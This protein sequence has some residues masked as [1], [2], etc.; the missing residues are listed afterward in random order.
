MRTR[1]WRAAPCVADW[2]RIG[3][4]AARKA[5]S[6]GNERDI[7]YCKSV[8]GADSD[9]KMAHSLRQVKGTGIRLYLRRLWM[10]VRVTRKAPGKPERQS[11]CTGHRTPDHSAY[12]RAYHRYASRRLRGD[13]A[14]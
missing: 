8:I 14:A 4:V 2:P 1:L 3:I 12:A 5:R 9:G 11:L 6:N 10:L 7:S 13:R